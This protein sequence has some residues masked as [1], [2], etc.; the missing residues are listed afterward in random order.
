MYSLFATAF[1][2]FRHS[3]DVI[4]DAGGHRGRHADCAIDLEKII[5]AKVQR[6]GS[7]E[8]GQVLA[9]CVGQPRKPTMSASCVWRGFVTM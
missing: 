8:I 6:D 4:L 9:E 3:P 1:N 2:Q 7:L 5:L